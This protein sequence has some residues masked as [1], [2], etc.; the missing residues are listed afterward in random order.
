MLR[1]QGLMVEELDGKVEASEKCL[2]DLGGNAF[3]SPCIMAS[4][5]ACLG[6]FQFASESEDEELAAISQTFK[7]ISFARSPDLEIQ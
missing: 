2:G 6:A 1:L 5:L 7:A 4:V 3:A